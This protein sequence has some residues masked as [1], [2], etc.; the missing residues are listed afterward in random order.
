MPIHERN[1]LNTSRAI[2]I[3][4]DGSGTAITIDQNGNGRSLFIDSEATT[5]RVI[6][7]ELANTDGD[8]IFIT[9]NGNHV[10]ANNYVF[11]VHQSH[12]S[13]VG[14]AVRFIHDGDG[15]LL[16]LN[17]AGTGTHINFEGDPV[18]ASSA[19]G[20][21]WFD[22]TNLKINVGGTVYN[23]DVTAA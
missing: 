16:K 10:D 22:G 13:S 7:I 15:L 18:N 14:G 4:N 3:T 5:A 8:A 17:H 2:T 23:V 11:N 21:F 6:E 20:D 19:D 12:A 1:L 9:N